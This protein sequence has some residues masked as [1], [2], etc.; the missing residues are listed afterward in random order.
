MAII[1]QLFRD[2][3]SIRRGKKKTNKS[4]TEEVEGGFCGQTEKKYEK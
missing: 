1:V 3:E 2:P 4:R